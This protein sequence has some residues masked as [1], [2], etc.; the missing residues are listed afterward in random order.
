R[1][2]I[3]A[4]GS[5]ALLDPAEPGDRTR[6]GPWRK[7][8][9]AIGRAA[10]ANAALYVIDPSGIP[11]PGSEAYGLAEATGGQRF[12]TLNVNGAFAQIW[13]DLTNYY[14]LSYVPLTPRPV[15]AIA[16]SVKRPGVR[17]RAR[18]LRGE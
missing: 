17:V 9:D 4:I 1:R 18:R 6:N 10:Q 12:A 5:P 16:V 3:V 7:W 15:H 14:V 11:H 8:V 2:A 13:R